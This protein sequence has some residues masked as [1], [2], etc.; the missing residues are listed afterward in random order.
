[1]L[2]LGA[3]DIQQEGTFVW[4]TSK[5]VLTAATFTN[6]SPG[7]PD[8]WQG[9]ENCVHIWYNSMWNDANCEAALRA[10]CEVVYPCN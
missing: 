9:N 2:W 8:N 10:L 7:Q 3:S 5:T 6:W 4:E 1:M